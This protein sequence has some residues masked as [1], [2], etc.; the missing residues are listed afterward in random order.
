MAKSIP[1]N[2][3]AVVRLKAE[4]LRRIGIARSL[5][6]LGGAAVVG[7][8]V[9]LQALQHAELRAEGERRR[10]VE[11]PLL[12]VRGAILDRHGKPLAQSELCCHI[13]IDP[14]S[15]REVDT[16]ARLLAQHLG[17]D[18]HYW[19]AQ[20]LQAQA[21]RRRYLRVAV[22]SPLSHYERLKKAC[23][24]S[25]KHLKRDER[26]V[27]YREELPARYYP[28]GSLAPQVLGLTQLVEDKK[29]GNRLV[30]TSGI[31]RSYDKRLAGTNGIEQGERTPYGYLIPETVRQRI[32]PRDGN[33]VQLTLDAAIQQAAE[34][35]LEQL[36]RKH[37]PKGALII[38][39]DPHTGDLL[40]IANRP[41]FDLATREGL[42]L[43]RN[44]SRAERDRA[45]EPTRNRAVEFLYEPG[46]TV[47]PLVVAALL[48]AG[49]YKPT[50]RFHCGG[51]Y[52]VSKKRIRCSENKRHGNQTLEDVICHS[53]N[54]AMAQMGLRAGLEGVYSA[55]QRFHLFEPMRAGFAYE[56][57]G[58]TIPPDKVRW[59][60]ELRAANLAFGQGLLTTPLA[61]AAAYGALANEGRWIAP[62][63]VLDPPLKREPPQQIIAPEHARLV[64]QGLVRAVEEGTGKQAQVK[65]YWAAGKTGTAQK[66]LEGGRGYA[67]GKYVASFVGMIPAENPRAV[68]LVLA[69]E[70]Q[71]GYYGGEVAAPAFRQVAQ[72]LMWYW[73]IPST[74]RENTR[75]PPPR[76]ARTG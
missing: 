49:V 56:E 64:I 21:Q 23:R 6:T 59:G 13:T 45:M 36:D 33:P 37:R 43:A 1:H 69:D 70:P 24:E 34:D 3:H 28:Q 46:S 31:E 67:S 63:I 72:F 12:A 10:Q 62:R 26:P 40:A 51:A 73:R 57:V 27:V 66:A 58:R 2:R 53:C 42:R 8:L 38:V 19:Q 9:H 11:R 52:P 15:I 47:K 68:I 39:L 29:Q 48:E 30:A 76:G 32:A 54:V 71:N 50:S 14:M 7:R 61:L 75:I 25:F 18:T 5:L 17:K 4:E 20:I 55:L 22:K 65:G 44:D 35:A 60:R 41:T 74:R 16:F